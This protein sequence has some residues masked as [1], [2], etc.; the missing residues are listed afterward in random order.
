[1]ENGKTPVGHTQTEVYRDVVIPIKFD[2]AQENS[3]YH[4]GATHWMDFVQSAPIDAS[5]WFMQIMLGLC[6]N[7]DKVGGSI[8]KISRDDNAKLYQKI[9]E[10]AAKRQICPKKMTGEEGILFNRYVTC[11]AY[12][13][14][15]F[16]QDLVD[17]VQ[18][19]RS[20]KK[21]PPRAA[22][23]NK[24]KQKGAEG[25][26]VAAVETFEKFLENRR[27]IPQEMPLYFHVEVEFEDDF[28]VLKR[29]NGD[30][31]AQLM[32]QAQVA[33]KTMAVP[34]SPVAEQEEEEPPAAPV[35]LQPFYGDRRLEKVTFTMVPIPMTSGVGFRGFLARFVIR[36]PSVNP[37]IFFGMI[38]DN[39]RLRREP[40]ANRRSY[41]STGSGNE[42]FPHYGPVYNSGH[43]LG[44]HCSVELYAQQAVKI[45]P[46]L[47]N[48][49]TGVSD[50]RRHLDYMGNTPAHIYQ[51][52]PI[53]RALQ[54]FDLDDSV[55]DWL[56]GFDKIAKFPMEGYRY[57]PPQ[58]FWVH[59]DDYGLME[60][61][62]PF[63]NHKSNLITK[64]S[65]GKYTLEDL[66]ASAPDGDD[67]QEGESLSTTFTRAEVILMDNVR[68]NKKLLATTNQL[69]YEINDDFVHEADAADRIF[70]NLKKLTPCDQLDTLLEVQPLLQRYGKAR[71]R[72]HASE[73]LLER[74]DKGELYNDVLRQVYAERM[75]VFCSLW[76]WKGD[77][78]GAA[79]SEPIKTILTW[80]RDNESSMPNVSRPYIRWDPE[81]DAFGNTQLQQMDIYIHFARVLQPMICMLSEGM[82]SCYEHMM[83]D[84]T[85]NM[86]IHG[87]F[88]V[89]KTFSAIFTLVKFSTIAQTVVEFSMQTKASDLTRLHERDLMRAADECPRWITSGR[90]AEKNPELVDKAKIKMTRNQ[91][92]QKTFVYV[93]VP[94]T[95]EKVRWNE[96]IV[97]DSKVATVYVTN[98]KV[99][100]KR[101]LSSRM[102]RI[103]A[104]QSNTPAQ[105]MVGNMDSVLKANTQRWLHLNQ[106][107]S[108]CLKKAGAVGCVTRTA[109][110]TL[111]KQISNRTMH[112]LREW[113][114][115]A[116]N[117]GPRS[118]EIMIPYARQLVDKM[119]IRMYYDMPWSPGFQK[120]FHPSQMQHVQRYRY[121]TTSIAWWTLTACASEWINDDNANVLRG[122]I[123]DSAVDWNVSGENAYDAF[124]TD[125]CSKI[126][127]RRLP[128]TE[129]QKRV[130]GVSGG[131]NPGGDNGA[132]DKNDEWLVNLNYL[133]VLGSIEQ[134]SARVAQHTHPRMSANDV[135]ST[136]EN[137]RDYL[138]K[139]E[140]NGYAPQPLG[141]FTRWHKYKVLPNEQTNTLG[142]K[143]MGPGCPERWMRETER[144]QNNPTNVIREERTEDDVDPL[145]IEPTK[146]PVIDMTEIRNGRLFFNPNSIGVFNQAVLER[147]L[148]A[149]ICCETT[150]RGKY[151][152][153]FSDPAD[154]TRNTICLLD[155]SA[156]RETVRKIDAASGHVENRNGTVVYT[157][158]VEDE[159]MRPVSRRVGI[160]FNNRGG[161]DREE[162][163]IIASTQW[164][165]TVPGDDSW[166][167][168]QLNGVKLMSKT[169]EIIPDLDF[170]SAALQ[171]SECGLPMDEPV[172]DPAFIEKA[173][174]DWCRHNEKAPD[175]GRDYPFDN[176]RVRTRLNETWQEMGVA[177]KIRESMDSVFKEFVTGN[178]KRTRAERNTAQN[179]APTQRA[180]MASSSAGELSGNTNAMATMESV[181]QRMRRSA[182]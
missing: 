171:H 167:D 26:A 147:A 57:D 135:Q 105:E 94:G 118:T 119:A 160:V 122:L 63:A 93:D 77:I 82:F 159:E 128:N 72:A 113:G 24:K 41:G 46:D 154:A 115:L 155:D 16:A 1:M 7:L 149:A 124:T 163:D 136:I 121:S 173:Y 22:S 141:S 17:T 59:R 139:V 11:G 40:S 31:S 73:A 103:T 81:M 111:F 158:D 64:L 28:A 164:A 88:D 112:Y 5:I 168:A 153:G 107:L 23:R 32:N 177:P 98:A 100:E 66:S 102:M 123:A 133:C 34:Q 176:Q 44:N 138:V 54:V 142:E 37:G 104:K 130:V 13:D 71:W 67:N 145:S 2:S 175:L 15:G 181:Q 62:F 70:S 68:V 30:L 96:N 69:G 86:M 6:D 146:I 110:M 85:Y 18:R 3:G 169:R 109:N 9:V 117:V 161:L 25:E 58:V 157:G 152:Q 48:S 99:E 56:N 134:I 80:Y 92:T 125:I 129:F 172:H 148:T 90:E 126:P 27:I 174:E 131:D 83:G 89:G 95:G 65:S 116:D 36:D 52:F 35:D 79:V 78:S 179:Q 76:Q 49:Y 108:C 144:M 180:R 143:Q 8:C 55:S 10:I 4:N 84:L 61:Y 74:Y 38:L 165:P 137:L 12:Y 60:Q 51:L 87:R 42:Y 132:Y 178:S 45:N 39:L 21:G 114:H 140:R 14:P 19:M 166:K 162:G 120:P 47:V 20:T 170:Y 50:L 91:L 101:A 156:I 29:S 75:K 182:E 33:A 106:F 43:P 53:E 97:T 127:F 151:L 150:R